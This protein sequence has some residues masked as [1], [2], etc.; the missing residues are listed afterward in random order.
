MVCAPHYLDWL[1]PVSVVGCAFAVAG[2]GVQPLFVHAGGKVS[3]S[4][5]EF[6][7]RGVRH[8]DYAYAGIRT[9]VAPSRGEVCPL[10]PHNPRNRRIARRRFQK[11]ARVFRLFFGGSRG[12]H[13]DAERALVLRRKMVFAYE[14]RSVRAALRKLEI[15]DVV[16]VRVAGDDVA[17]VGG[18]ARC[19]FPQIAAHAETATQIHCAG[20]DFLYGV[21]ADLEVPAGVRLLKRD[22]VGLSG[23]RLRNERFGFQEVDERRIFRPPS[24]VEL[25]HG[26]V[27]FFED[28]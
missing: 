23:V 11:F 13:R 9:V 22:H 24:R 3:E 14:N 19:V 28:F 7:V 10:E 15:R 25:F 18:Y 26:A 20:V 17:I 8:V 2:F 21:A 16:A 12:N 4:L 5:D 1:I 6:V 27:F